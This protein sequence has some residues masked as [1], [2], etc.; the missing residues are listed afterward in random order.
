MGLE[1]FSTCPS[2]A[3]TAVISPSGISSTELIRIMRDKFGIWIA[4]G[5]GKMKGKIFRI[6]H[7]GYMDRFDVIVALSALE[8]SLRE[9]GYKIEL[10]KGVGTAERILGGENAQG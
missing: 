6:A 4:N 1:L 5:Q 10:G 3:L 7:L 2:N 9:M 8:M